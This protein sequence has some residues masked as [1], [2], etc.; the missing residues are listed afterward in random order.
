MSASPS[1]FETVTRSEHGTPFGKYELLHRLAVGGMA[2]IFRARSNA[3]GGVI[4]TC[5]IKRILP[6]LC[7]NRQFVSMFIDEA[8]I[9]I[10]LH[11]ENIVRLYDFGQVDGSYYMALEFV[12]GCDLVAVLERIYRNGQGMHPLAAA[13]VGRGL[14][15]GLHHAHIQQDAAG[16]PLGIVHRDVSPHNVLLSW[17]GDVKVTDFGIAQAKHKLTLTTPGTV[18]GKFAYMAPEQAAGTKVDARA[19]VFAVGVVLHEALAGQRLFAGSTPIETI[20]KLMHQQVQPPSTVKPG[21]PRELDQVV[22]RALEK[23]PAARFQSAEEMGAALLDAMGRAGGYTVE[24]FRTYLEQMM[25]VDPS[26]V[27][28]RDGTQSLRAKVPAPAKRPATA[29]R[30]ATGVTPD[31]ELGRLAQSLR[32]D[33]NVWTLVAMG[34]RHLELG[35]KELAASAFRVAAGAFAFRGL[36]I[37]ALVAHERAR[38]LITPEQREEDINFLISLRQANLAVLDQFI[39]RVD[40][41]G[42]YELLRRADEEA[43][44]ENSASTRILTPVPLYGTV[45]PSDLPRLLGV[46]RVRRYAP[47]QVIV[48]EGEEGDT[49][50]AVGEGRVVVYCKPP[51]E[52]RSAEDRVYLSSL[53]EGDFFGEFGFLSGEPRTASVEAVLATWVLEIDRSQ[54]EE[55]VALSPEMAGPLLDFY[56]ARVVELLMAKS[57]LFAPLPPEDRR[58]LLSRA[59]PLRYKDNEIIIQEGDDGDAFFFIKQG[60]V[61]VFSERAGIPIFINKLREGQF[62]GEIAAIKGTRRTA[63]IRA[64]GDVELLTFSRADLQAL[65]EKRPQLR[66]LLEAA[67]IDRVTEAVEQVK[68]ATELLR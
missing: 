2:E 33:P 20:G 62:F 58:H 10:G 27:E 31:K 47:G 8:R 19:D 53:S 57:P 39:S 14:C 67:I 21:I 12:S 17:E 45:A 9:L 38:P 60:E 63:S 22:M 64:M 66:A 11:H 68:A 40:V 46:A 16:R 26:A 35:R 13:W 65:I 18:M 59:R 56:K 24:E 7:E 5:V 51:A 54:V 4:R 28:K 23:D 36:L 48:R 61:E 25:M 37:Q 43:F 29:P 32:Q 3:L 50:F 44:G 49:L 6:E 41:G 15:E 55:L 34:A 42:F 52:A 1:D 30:V